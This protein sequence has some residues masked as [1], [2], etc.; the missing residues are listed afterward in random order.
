MLSPR[1]S[2]LRDSIFIL[3]FLAKEEQ[4]QHTRAYVRTGK[5]LVGANNQFLRLTDFANLICK[6]LG[7]FRTI[8][9]RNRHPLILGING[10][11]AVNFQNGFDCLFSAT[12][13]TQRHNM[14]GGIAP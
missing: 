11:G 13:F 9:V 12:A 6:I 14:A 3:S 2:I 8:T 1:I 10:S 7:F 5:G 4:C